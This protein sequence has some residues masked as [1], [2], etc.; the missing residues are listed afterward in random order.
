MKTLSERL[1]A[2][3]VFLWATAMLLPGC[4]PATTSVDAGRDTAVDAPSACEQACNACSILGCDL[5][6]ESSS[7]AE[8]FLAAEG[9][10]EMRACL[11]G[12]P[13]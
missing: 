12:P 10:E 11:M 2:C 6:C 8:C 3:V 5:M 1:A 4:D 13:P 9:C 7:R